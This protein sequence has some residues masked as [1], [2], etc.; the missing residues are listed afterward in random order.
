M[1]T[2][3]KCLVFSHIYNVFKNSENILIFHL[4]KN[5]IHFCVTNVYMQFPCRN[6]VV[7]KIKCCRKVK[8]RNS[9]GR[10]LGLMVRDHACR[11]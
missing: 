8:A 5:L 4:I 6:R 9:L 3:K 2:C 10:P 11:S 1:F 7:C